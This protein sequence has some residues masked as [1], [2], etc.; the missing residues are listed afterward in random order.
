MARAAALKEYCLAEQAYQGE[1]T[2]EDLVCLFGLPAHLNR[3]WSFG[4][5]L[6]SCVQQW[7]TLK[8]LELRIKHPH[9]IQPLPIWSE[10]VYGIIR[11]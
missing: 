7:C 4:I 8:Y 6:V 2:P 10:A 5:S 3:S 1:D 11:K 9:L